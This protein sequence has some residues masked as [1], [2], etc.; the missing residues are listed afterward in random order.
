MGVVAAISFF[1]SN[2]PNPAM[3]IT[4]TAVVDHGHYSKIAAAN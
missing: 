1:C 4:K 3:L 2:K